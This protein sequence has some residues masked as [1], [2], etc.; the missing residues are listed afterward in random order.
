MIGSKIQH[1]KDVLVIVDFC[2]MIHRE[3][4]TLENALDLIAYDAQWVTCSKTD[5]VGGT[6]QVETFDACLLCGYLF[7]QLVDAV[8]G[9]LLQFVDL[10]ANF[11]L[12][13]WCHVTEVSHY[14]INFTFLTQIF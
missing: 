8:H 1:S 3:A 12:L 11:T 7:S 5:R 2:T 9:S 14:G 4:H 10:D 13:V 6:C